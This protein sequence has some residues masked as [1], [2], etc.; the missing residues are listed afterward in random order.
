MNMQG[1]S[2]TDTLPLVKIKKA[3]HS[4]KQEILTLDI[5]IGVVSNTLLQAQMREKA[6]GKK[7]HGDLDILMADYELDEHLG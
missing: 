3:I 2:V 5:R 7:D 4:M 6:M 1:K